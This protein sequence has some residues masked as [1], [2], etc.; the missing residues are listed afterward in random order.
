MKKLIFGMLTGIFYI[1]IAC[2]YEQT[3]YIT[4]YHL[5]SDARY[6]SGS[7]YGDRAVCV[8][9][10]PAVPTWGWACL[11]NGNRLYAEINKLL[12]DGYMN[13]KK[14]TVSGSATN[15]DAFLIIS[16]VECE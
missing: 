9:M 15:S 16:L 12:S 3:G 1:G 11:Y 5:N 4:K 8:Q 10:L 13:K 7:E 2:A 6:V 14:C